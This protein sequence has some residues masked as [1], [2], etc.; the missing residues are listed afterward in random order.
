MNQ[1]KTLWIENLESSSLK[2]Q[3]S[4]FFGQYCTVYE[5]STVLKFSIVCNSWILNLNPNQHSTSLIELVIFC[6]YEKIL[7]IWV[8]RN[9]LLTLKL[10]HHL[11]RRFGKL[12]QFAG[13]R[14]SVNQPV[15]NELVH[16]LHCQ[17]TRLLTQ[18]E[19]SNENKCGLQTWNK[20]RYKLLSIFFRN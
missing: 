15:V 16:E 18:K 12:Q 20:R 8:V 10:L 2:S 11:N 4:N 17:C 3:V 13:N 19:N 6:Q 5:K 1:L 9:S 7:R 14:E